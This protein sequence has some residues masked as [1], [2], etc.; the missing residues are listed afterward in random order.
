VTEVLGIARILCRAPLPI[1]F[2]AEQSMGMPALSSS[3]W[4]AADVLA[5]PE[6]TRRRYEC[7]DGELLVSPSPRLVHQMAV[8]VLALRL[9][10]LL[11]AQGLAV[12]VCGPSD[13][14]LDDHTLVQPDV[15]VVPLFEGRRPR[16]DEERTQPFLFVEVLSPHTARFDRVIKRRRYQRAA[17]EYWIVDLDARLVER[18]MPGDVQPTI[19]TGSFEWVLPNATSPLVVPVESV[20]NDV[21]GPANDTR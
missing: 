21:L 5:L 7:V 10:R 17:I 1:V 16:T 12:V 15:Y 9:D 3:E 19:H 4:T 14:V 8:T 18:W 6:D 2:R 13:W 20:F 11:S